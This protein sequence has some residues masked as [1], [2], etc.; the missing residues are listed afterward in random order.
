VLEGLMSSRF[1]VPHTQTWRES[2]ERLVGLGTSGSAG[3]TDEVPF[4][5]A[6]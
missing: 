4:F 2:K 6:L 1:S 5:S 3:R